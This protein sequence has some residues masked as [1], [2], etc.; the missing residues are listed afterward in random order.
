M[1]PEPA[2]TADLSISGSHLISSLCKTFLCYLLAPFSFYSVN[3]IERAKTVM[4]TWDHMS[5]DNIVDYY[6]F[7]VNLLY[8]FLQMLKLQEF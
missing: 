8:I 7:L 6:R 4:C 3:V 1:Q 2:Q 5:P